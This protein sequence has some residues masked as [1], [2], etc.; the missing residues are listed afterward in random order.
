MFCIVL[1]MVVTVVGDVMSFLED[2][3]EKNIP[4]QAIVSFYFNLA[5]FA[6]VNMVPFAALLAGVYVFNTLSRTHELTAVIASGMSLWRLIRPILFF[7]AILCV[8]TFIV[9]D[10]IVPETMRKANTIKEQEIKLS[11]E[12]DSIEDLTFYGKGGMIIYA[13]LYHLGEKEFDDVI[14]H[15]QDENNVVIEKINARKIY[16]DDSQWIGKDVIVFR[17]DAM[18]GFDSDPEIYKE[19]PISIQEGPQEFSHTQWNI[20]FMSYAQLKRHLQVFKGASVDRAV[21]RLRV[22]L[23]YKIAFP[24]IAFI[25]VLVGIPF[26]VETGRASALVGMAKGILIA[27][28]Y[29]PVLAI[30]L[31]LGKA[32]V[33]PPVMSAWLSNVIFAVIGIVQIRR[34]S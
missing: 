9:N 32:G 25:T 28:L 15:R 10:R 26:S 24:F 6:F 31:A 19:K 14:I 33:L 16:W 17:R 4:A 3:F 23:N 12:G 2:I 18:E 34:K 22:D 8:V 1:L 5:P 11:S 13:K 29:L 27:I 7:T 21:R 30:S 20:N